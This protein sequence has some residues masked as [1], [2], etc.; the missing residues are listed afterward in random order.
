MYSDQENQRA[1]IGKV[2]VDYNSNKYRLRWTYPIGNRNQIRLDVNWQEALRIAK[3]INRDI[4][5]NDV[6]L[7]YGR[8]SAKHAQSI[9]IA[10]KQP[11]LL[12]LWETYKETSKNRVAA[13]TIKKQCLC[14]NINSQER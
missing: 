12:D 9:Q 13:T 3:I 8:Y 2:N 10:D 14:C 4:E 1:K 5:I 7:S 6:D 11:N